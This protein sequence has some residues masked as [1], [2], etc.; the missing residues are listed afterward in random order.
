MLQ[1]VE[2]VEETVQG[3]RVN[4]AEIRRVPPWTSHQAATSWN[5]KGLVISSSSLPHKSMKR[6]GMKLGGR[7]GEAGRERG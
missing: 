1:R 2:M 6:E 4:S 5:N 3:P 7:D